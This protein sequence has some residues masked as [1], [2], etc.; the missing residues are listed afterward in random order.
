MDS[1]IPVCVAILCDTRLGHHD[2]RFFWI[3]GHGDRGHLLLLLRLHGFELPFAAPLV[4][5]GT[6]LG[7]EHVIPPAEAGGI[8]ANKFLVVQVVVIG[9]SPERQKMS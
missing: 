2:G 1:R 6:R 4:G 7:I 8:V 9:T 5:F 3:H